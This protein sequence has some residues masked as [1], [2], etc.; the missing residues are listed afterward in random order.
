MIIFTCFPYHL[1]IFMVILKCVEMRLCRLVCVDDL[2]P[3]HPP[4]PQT[5]HHSLQRNDNQLIV[6]W[7]WSCWFLALAV[8]LGLHWIVLYSSDPMRILHHHEDRSMIRYTVLSFQ[9]PA[10]R[11]DCCIVSLLQFAKWS[12]LVQPSCKYQ[13][14]TW[15]C[16]IDISCFRQR[17]RKR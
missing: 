13:T 5:L 7:L 1:N 8:E 3:S 12:R 14:A 6:K 11:V 4:N 15:M 2:T 9:S 10:C 16:Q 17:E